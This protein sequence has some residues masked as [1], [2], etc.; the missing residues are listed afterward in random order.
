MVH[1]K[2][3]QDPTSNKTYAIYL[4]RD[5]DAQS[6]YPVVFVFDEKGRG[7]LITQQFSIGAALTSSIVIGANYELDSTIKPALKQMEELQEITPEL[8]ERP[9]H[10]PLQYL[11]LP[12]PIHREEEGY[13]RGRR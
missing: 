8:C 3:K 2:V 4:P 5:Y 1:P 9:Y 10:I 13:R 6:K 11:F 12:T 7:D